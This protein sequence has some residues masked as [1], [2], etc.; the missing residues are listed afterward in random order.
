MF[1]LSQSD[2]YNWP[3]TVE[4]PADGGR[5]E[6]STFDAEFKRLTQSRI[7]EIRKLIEREE[8]RDVDLVREVMVGW[9]SVVDQNGEVPFSAQALDQ[10]LEV[11]MVAGSIVLA[12]FAS[13]S[14]AKRKN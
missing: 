14:G 3:V 6:K 11:P 2:T 1:K 8:I 9:S 4:V 7:E 10:L 5:T 12:L 13:L